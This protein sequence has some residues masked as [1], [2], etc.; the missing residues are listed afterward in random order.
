[1]QI[2]NSIPFLMFYCMRSPLPEGAGSGV[3]I[4][5]RYCLSFSRKRMKM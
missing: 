4:L 1:M 3:W 2:Q 5:V